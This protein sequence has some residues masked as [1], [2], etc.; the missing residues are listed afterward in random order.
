MWFHEELM[1]ELSF[2]ISRQ[3]SLLLI[4]P[5]LRRR[6]R[7]N[8]SGNPIYAS[9]PIL[10]SYSL[11]FSYSSTISSCRYWRD[12]HPSIFL[13][14]YSYINSIISPSSIKNRSKGH[15]K[16]IPHQNYLNFDLPRLHFTILSIFLKS[17]ILLIHRYHL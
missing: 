3:R 2:F 1:L 12:H 5:D 10:F 17:F 4:T 13:K 9:L 11:L 14:N 15:F 16:I 8:T 7:P 6:G